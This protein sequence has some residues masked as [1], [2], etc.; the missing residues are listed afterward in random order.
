MRGKVV[1]LTSQL[2]GFQNLLRTIANDCAHL[3]AV[4]VCY[5]ISFCGT[6]ICAEYYTIFEQAPNNGC[7]GRGG[8]GYF[9]TFSGQEFIPRN[10]TMS[11]SS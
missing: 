5:D 11:R 4:L 1:N 8:L 7:S 6:S 10:R 9:D 2:P 3:L